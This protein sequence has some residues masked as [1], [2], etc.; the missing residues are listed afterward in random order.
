MIDTLLSELKSSLN[1][2]FDLCVEYFQLFI[3][4]YRRDVISCKER[5]I[6]CEIFCLLEDME[7]LSF[8]PS[9]STV[10]ASGEV[11]L[12]RANL[13][14]EGDTFF[15]NQEF[16]PNWFTENGYDILEEHSEQDLASQV[17]RIVLD[18]CNN[19]WKASRS[20]DTTDLYFT[21]HF[22]NNVITNLE[23]M[24]EKIIFL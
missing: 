4:E 7:Y 17:K 8:L 5:K 11:A 12:D 9:F 10:F 3:A 13:G 24:E 23:T 15:H 19:A 16:M 18:W 20:D 6:E 22:T 21:D 2:N 14:G 1:E